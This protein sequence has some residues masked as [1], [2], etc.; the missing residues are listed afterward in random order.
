MSIEFFVAGTIVG[1]VAG[2][3]VFGSRSTQ[4]DLPENAQSEWD[5]DKIR[6]AFDQGGRG[7]E[8]LLAKYFAI[9][10]SDVEITQK[11][12]DGGYDIM[13]EDSNEKIIIEAKM[14]SGSVEAETARALTGVATTKGADKALI[15]TTSDLSGDGKKHFKEF[16]ENQSQTKAKV[17][18]GDEIC[19]MLDRSPLSPPWHR[20]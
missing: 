9:N 14:T 6:T 12:R 3:S 20:E 1:L 7:F 4:T 2:V 5:T 10:Y 15:I 8:F 13:A 18:G 19:D 16:N 17:I 11:T